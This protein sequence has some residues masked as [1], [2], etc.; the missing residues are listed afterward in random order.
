M[1]RR[2]D[3]MAS[4]KVFSGRPE[5][6]PKNLAMIKYPAL[7]SLKYDGWRMFEY[8]GEVRNRSLK[9]PKNLHTQKVMRELFASAASIGCKG[10]DGEVIAS[11]P[12]DP[13]SMQ[14]CTSAFGSIMGEPKFTY[15]IFDCYQ[16]QDRPFRERLEQATNAVIQLQGM[17][18]DW[19]HPVEHTLVNNE[20]EMFEYYDRVIE[21]GG[22]GIMGRD[23]EGLYKYG[24]STMKQSWLWALKPYVDDE[25]VIIGFDEMLENQ[26]EATTNE[27]GYTSR[28]GHAENMVP[29]GTLGRFKCRSSKWNETFNV[30]MGVGLNDALRADV[31]AN[32]DKY[33][34]RILKYKYQ[35]IGCVD[36]PRQPKFMGFRDERD[37][38]QPMSGELLGIL[39]MKDK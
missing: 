17:G 7:V 23:P 14:K 30:G 12:Y 6:T 1:S 22:E 29:K 8:G 16:Y 38:A 19:I 9:P 26:N 11:G 15:N 2:F 3:A 28:A 34:G 20:T 10:L 13:N 37:M 35:E 21:L 24:R 27:R 36:R 32:R 39:G 33:L 18:Y 31:W 4:A 5:E 25:A